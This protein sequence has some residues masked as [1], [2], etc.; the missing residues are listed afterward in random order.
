M[1][2]A[3]PGPRS[4]R[5]GV[6]YVALLAIGVG[7][8]VLI[9]WWG[10]AR[11]APEAADAPRAAV[12]GKG[13]TL[14][15]VLLALGV[16]VLAARSV[17]RVFVWVGQPPVIGEVLAG[18]LL[19][20]SFLGAVAPTVKDALIRPETYEILK[21]LA[22]LGVILYLFLV[23]LE[24]DTA[25]LGRHGREAVLIAH[26]GIVVPFLLGSALAV[27]LYPVVSSAAV[28]F[29]RFALFLGV[30]MAITAFPVLARI[31]TDRNLSRTPLGQLALTCAAIGDATAWCALA[32]VVGFARSQLDSA[33]WVLLGTVAF[34]LLMMFAV[35]PLLLWWLRRQGERVSQ[36]SV[37]VLLVGV[38]ATAWATE[39]IG[40]HALFGAFLFGALL[41]H[42]HPAARQMDDKLRDAVSVLLLPAYFA[43]TGLRTEL[44]TVEGWHDWLW[45]GLIVLV[46][47][48]GKFGGT[49]L[50]AR[51]VGLGWRDGSALGVL[52][53]TR[54]LMELV[55]LNIGR[56]HGILSKK[57]YAMMVVMAV[58]TT[59]ATAPLLR[60]LG[61]FGTSPKEP[62]AREQAP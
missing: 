9:R 22:Q 31:L 39:V 19:G 23:G 37:A 2:A 25:L 17:G 40:I 24:L 11:P 18:I 38:L 42:D 51:T 46:A 16:I 3:S 55:V 50:A 26:A 4:G 36:E 58:V 33:A 7:L 48:A 1:I 47:T 28:G 59:V 34:F 13:E 32:L 8:F 29:T 60:L 45:C 57:L 62:P 12:E 15:H 10:E 35:R 44:G 56:D 52:M 41:P 49:L 20:P 6:V 53:N 14:P 30:A 61:V 27:G 54:G 5:L 21:A 43:F